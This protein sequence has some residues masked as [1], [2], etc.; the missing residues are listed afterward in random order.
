MRAGL[1]LMAGPARAAGVR[2]VWWWGGLAVHGL[3]QHA[4]REQFAD[5]LLAVKQQG[6]GQ[7][8]A[9][10][11]GL[12]EPLRP[13]LADDGVKR[14]GVRPG[15]SPPA[16]PAAGAARSGRSRGPRRLRRPCRLPRA[17]GAYSVGRW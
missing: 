15:L 13:L 9:A 2:R 5:P 8:L 12:E 1:D 3:R 7:A 16:A 14:H 6:M 17:R 4:D 11:C 10:Q